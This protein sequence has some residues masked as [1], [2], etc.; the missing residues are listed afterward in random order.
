MVLNTIW[1]VSG[2]AILAWHQMYDVYG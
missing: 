1:M 2:W